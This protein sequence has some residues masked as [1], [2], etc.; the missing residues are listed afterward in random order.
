LLRPQKPVDILGGDFDEDDHPYVYIETDDGKRYS[1]QYPGDVRTFLVFNRC[2]VQTDSPQIGI[3]D[4]GCDSNSKEV[5]RHRRLIISEP[6]GNVVDRIRL[7]LCGELSSGVYEYVLLDDGTVWV[8]SST[9]SEYSFQ[10]KILWDLIEVTL[11][12]GIWVC[13]GIIIGLI[14]SFLWLKKLKRDD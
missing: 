1:C 9:R 12:V 2:W 3:R 11:F 13:P 4:K 6:P 7:E 10:P 5:A 14:L 8:W